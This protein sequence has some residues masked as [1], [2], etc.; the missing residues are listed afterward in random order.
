MLE[1]LS[2]KQIQSAERTLAAGT[3]TITAGAVLFSVLTVTP[4]VEKVT[5]ADWGWTAPILPLV[6]DAAVVIV[7]RLDAVVARLGGHAGKWPAVLR[8]MT[9][10]MT[11]LL[12]VGDSALKSDLVGVAVHSV[13]PLLLIVT[14][15]AGLAYRRAINAALERIERSRAA[16]A[17]E[18]EQRQRAERERE[19]REREH[20][21]QSARDH[22]ERLD[23]ERAEREANE[24]AAERDHTARMD[25]ERLDRED[26]ARREQR[27]YEDRVRREE[28]ES[29]DALR[30][31][32]H[33]QQER[34]RREQQATMQAAQVAGETAAREAV[35][36]SEGTVNT[37][38]NTHPTPFTKMPET[39]ARSYIRSFRE[40]EKSVRQLADDTGW[41]V[42]WIAARVQE[43]REQ[44][45]TEETEPAEAVA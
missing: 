33:E 8:W 32:Q 30:R 12:N 29:A 41:S 24:R 45:A 10:L 6:V 34:S 42:G 15:E 7:V 22:A 2:P 21:E 4:L 27:E 20:R 19:Q 40:G 25:R 28:R 26:K 14:A 35:N 5:P 44:Q 11:L 36:T 9:G 1:T 37:A 17:A 18:R 16:E 13:A 31:E 23:R 38:V 43:A 3:W 39:E